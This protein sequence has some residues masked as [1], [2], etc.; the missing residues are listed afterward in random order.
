M[1]SREIVCEISDVDLCCPLQW[2]LA[3][4]GHVNLNELKINKIKTQF[5]SCTVAIF[6]AFSDCYI[7]HCDAQHF[8]SPQKVLLYGA[9]L[10]KCGAQF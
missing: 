7:A 8:P 1:R 5:L 10:D 6:Q 2:P 4:Y 3:A 9:A